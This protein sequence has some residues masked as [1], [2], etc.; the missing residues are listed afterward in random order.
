[1][2][3]YFKSKSEFQEY[4]STLSK[5]SLSA[6][7]LTSYPSGTPR[8][9]CEPSFRKMN[10][11]NDL[12]S[13]TDIRT[14]TPPLEEIGIGT[15]HS[16]SSPSLTKNSNSDTE[17]FSPEEVILN[18]KL[19]WGLFITGETQPMP[20]EIKANQNQRIEDNKWL[21]VPLEFQDAT[22]SFLSPAPRDYRSLEALREKYLRFGN[23]EKVSTSKRETSWA[24]N[25]F[26]SSSEVVIEPPSQ[27]Q[28]DCS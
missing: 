15:T 9:V 14:T 11:E 16:R 26:R 1:M 3:S 10:S 24:K 17:T 4:E 2:I 28:S 22:I 18:L 21:E 7:D 12:E 6:S 19:L 5:Q 25:F 23:A 8:A 13:N 20:Q 27:I